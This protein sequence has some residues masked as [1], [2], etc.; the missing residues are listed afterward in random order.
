MTDTRNSNG[1]T[2]MQVKYAIDH[3]TGALENHSQEVLTL[4]NNVVI[5]EVQIKFS[6]NTLLSQ[7]VSNQGTEFLRIEIG[8]GGVFRVQHENKQRG[9]NLQFIGKDLRSVQFELRNSG[10]RKVTRN[11]VDKKTGEPKMRQYTSLARNNNLT[12]E[13]LTEVVDSLR[14]LLRNRASGDTAVEKEKAKARNENTRNY[15][16][17]RQESLK[18]LRDTIRNVQK[19]TGVSDLVKGLPK[20]NI[21]S[22]QAYTKSN[23]KKVGDTTGTVKTLASILKK[24]KMYTAEE[25]ES[26]NKTMQDAA[27][28]GQLVANEYMEKLLSKKQSSK[29]TNPAETES[30]V[31]SDSEHSNSLKLHDILYKEFYPLVVTLKNFDVKTDI[32]EVWENEVS[33]DDML[34]IRDRSEFE[35]V[36]GE[37]GTPESNLKKIFFVAR[38]TLNASVKAY[39]S[40]SEDEYWF[41]RD[42][43]LTFLF[44][45]AKKDDSAKVEYASKLFKLFKKLVSERDA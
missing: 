8:H 41:S 30:E 6:G 18:S 19:R 28:L 38:A 43:K 5:K 31:E 27:K 32:L 40:I 22:V 1:L 36:L 44:E 15:Q 16:N 39:L 14:A 11:E 13:F 20:T 25:A 7:Y 2:L 17:N 23:L 10:T 37:E 42:N 26:V 35:E 4:D 9:I 12:P 3:E 34:Y 24:H 45:R 21:S 29:D 33:N